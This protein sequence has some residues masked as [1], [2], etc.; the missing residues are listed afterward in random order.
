MAD[1]PSAWS[2]DRV[3]SWLADN[4]LS[5]LDSCFRRNRVD[6]RAL[7]SLTKGDLKDE[8]CIEALGDRKAL[9]DRLEILSHRRTSVGLPF[10]R[11]ASSSPVPVVSTYASP[12]PSSA[13]GDRCEH[14][15]K[16]FSLS[17]VPILL[18][19][20]GASRAAQLH[21]YCKEAWAR[22]HAKQCGYCYEPMTTK[23]TTL[24]GSFGKVELHPECEHLWSSTNAKKCHHCGS[25][26]TGDVTTLT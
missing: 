4:G 23:I 3:C 19:L 7:M 25:A 21:S 20:P 13:S 22:R 12:T 14:C 8:L 24:T 11:V 5:H 9:W 17:D 2:V 1:V 16:L 18:T 26:M 15:F 6:G 10:D